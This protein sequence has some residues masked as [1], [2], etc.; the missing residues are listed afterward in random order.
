MTAAAHWNCGVENVPLRTGAA[1]V[2]D[3][4]DLKDACCGLGVALPLAHVVDVGCGTGRWATQCVGG[5][6]GLDIAA[7]AVA[8]AHAAGVNVSLMVG[9]STVAA[10]LL[11]LAEVHWICCF[12][13]FTHI[14]RSERMAYLQAFAGRPGV[15]VLVDVIPGDGRGDI[16]LWTADWPTFQHD[17]GEAGFVL[18]VPAYDR[19]SPDGALHRY[20]WAQQE[21]H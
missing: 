10:I 14:D 19:I 17:L 21:A 5:Y 3:C 4:R 18:R 9:P 7:H 13:V 2:M 16:G 11:D 1:T 12:S 6:L 15:Q 20:V 8:Y